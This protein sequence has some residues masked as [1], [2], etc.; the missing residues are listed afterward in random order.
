MKSDRG[1]G[2]FSVGPGRLLLASYLT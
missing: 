2:L 1:V